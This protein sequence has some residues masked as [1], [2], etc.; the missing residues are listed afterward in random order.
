MH[1]R[2]VSN[3]MTI[4]VV[5]VAAAAVSS[6]AAAEVTVCSEQE[7]F[8]SDAEPQDLFGQSVAI[9]GQFV[10][11]GAYW[12]D[13]ACPKQLGCNSGAAYVYHLQG[14]TWNEQQKLVSLDLAEGDQFGQEVGISGDVA[15]VGANRD[16]DNGIDSGSAYVFRYDGGRWTQEQKLTA[17]DGA[18]EDGFGWGVDVDGNVAIVGAYS[19]DDNGRNSGSVY[20]FRFDGKSSEWVFEQKVVAI[21][22]QAGDFFGQDVSISGDGSSPGPGGPTTTAIG[23]VRPSSSPT[24]GNSGPRRGSSCLRTAQPTIGLAWRC[25]SAATWRSQGHF[26]IITTPVLPMSFND[27]AAPG[28]KCSRSK[29]PT[30]SLVTSSASKSASPATP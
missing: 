19:D 15:I 30:A 7:I 28:T 27:L 6:L 10:I 23:R 21:D 18:A 4:I 20:V 24:T 5:I 9:D 29:P 11:V 12:D 2:T 8:A 16:D 1:H 22:G 3:R 25:L 17:P 26:A 14:A 13:D